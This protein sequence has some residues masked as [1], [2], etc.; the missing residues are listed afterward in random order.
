MQCIHCWTLLCSALLQ[1]DGPGELRVCLIKA[2]FLVLFMLLCPEYGNITK[3]ISLVLGFSAGLGNLI[4]SACDSL[5]FI[6]RLSQAA[7]TPKP[8]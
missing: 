7:G 1:F 6:I 2:A 4:L 5:P 8:G 3:T